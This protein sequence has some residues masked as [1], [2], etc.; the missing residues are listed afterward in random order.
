M[1]RNS[2]E[3]GRLFRLG[4]GNNPFEGDCH[5][6][7]VEICTQ[8]LGV[9]GWRKKELFLLR[10]LIINCVSFK[11]FAIPQIV[12][13]HSIDHQATD[14]A[15][16]AFDP[17]LPSI[18]RRRRLPP[19]LPPPSSSIRRCRRH[20]RHRRCQLPPPPRSAAAASIR[21][22]HFRRHRLRSASLPSS[23]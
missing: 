2:T 3:N 1:H 13:S 10:L 12:P 19:P 21:R 17:P 4:D 6:G 20:L 18:R 7:I 14:R 11:F 8:Y 5:V 15:A 22:R 16:A 9:V 23:I